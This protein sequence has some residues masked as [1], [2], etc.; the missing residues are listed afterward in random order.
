MFKGIE[1]KVKME[2]RQHSLKQVL[3]DQ[4]DRVQILSV[5]F[6]R[7]VTLSKLSFLSESQFP[8]VYP[9]NKKRTRWIQLH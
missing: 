5:P 3:Y 6:A 2:K 9:G 8:H 7:S 1:N 4:I